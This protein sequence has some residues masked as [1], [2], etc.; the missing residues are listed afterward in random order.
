MLASTIS[1]SSPVNP[2]NSYTSASIAYRPIAKVIHN[3]S[4]G[5]SRR[6]L[7][8]DSSTLTAV[9][10]LRKTPTL[11]HAKAHLGWRQGWGL[12]WL[13]RLGTAKG[14]LLRPILAKP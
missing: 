5:R 14:A 10:C 6:S 12:C 1:I 7:R 3:R 11:G 8:K 9:T 2:Y 4:A 13:C